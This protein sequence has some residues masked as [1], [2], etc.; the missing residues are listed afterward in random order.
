[1]PGDFGRK[2]AALCLKS[3]IYNGVVARGKVTQTE[4]LFCNQLMLNVQ[5]RGIVRKL[6]N[7]HDSLSWSQHELE[8]TGLL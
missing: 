7:F 4:M 6:V 5:S 3:G 8:H 1:M 2:K